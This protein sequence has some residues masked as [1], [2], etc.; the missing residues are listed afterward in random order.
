M[1][2]DQLLPIFSK[3][4]FAFKDV[5]EWLQQLS[6]AWKTLVSA[7][8]LGVTTILSLKAALILLGGT[9]GFV[10][11]G[12][13]GAAA[14]ASIASAAMGPLIIAIGALA[15]ALVIVPKLFDDATSSQEKMLEASQGVLDVEVDRLKSMESLKAA[16]E[17][18]AATEEDLKKIVESSI[19]RH[20][21]LV[22]LLNKETITRE[23]ILEILDK[24]IEKRKEAVDV[25]LEQTKKLSKEQIEA[26]KDEQHNVGLLITS[27]QKLQE[28][29]GEGEVPILTLT[30]ALRSFEGEVEKSGRSVNNLGDH[31]RTLLMRMMKGLNSLNK[32]IL[33]LVLK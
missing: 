23:D 25:A 18:Q 2:G 10:K 31:M 29:Y 9:L 7:I 12:F 5:L 6:P 17:N 21:E 15:A 24:E 30:G 22:P 4:V 13:A 19:K 3:L 27:L 11:A 16:V 28:R 8:A 26:L 32:L 1:F 20:K 14:S 33:I